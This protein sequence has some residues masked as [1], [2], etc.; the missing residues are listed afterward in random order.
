MAGLLALAVCAAVW[1]ADANYPVSDA[2]GVGPRFDGV[3]ALSGGGGTSVYLRDYPPEQQQVLLDLLFKPGYG[4]ALQILKVEIGGDSQSTEAVEHS[5]MHTADDLNM[6]R[7]YEG[8]LL[9]Q[10]KARNPEIKTCAF[11]SAE[12]SRAERC[13]C[14]PCLGLSYQT[15]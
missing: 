6:E 9:A 1:V 5:H 7:G 10:A 15:A 4:A 2:A 13:C 12:R 14:A 3:G 8:W 11:E